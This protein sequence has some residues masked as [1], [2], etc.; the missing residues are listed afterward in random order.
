M[1]EEKTS[2]CN[3]ATNWKSFETDDFS[4]RY[5]PNFQ[6]ESLAG[7]RGLYLGMGVVKISF[8]DK[9]FEDENTTYRAAYLVVNRSSDQDEI[10]DCA[11]FFSHPGPFIDNGPRQ[12]EINGVTFTTRTIREGAAGNFYESQLYRSLH[13][14][15]C[16]EI[17]LVVHTVNR[18]NYTP[19]L[20]E[21]DNQKAYTRLEQ[22]R[23]TFSF[24]GKE[25]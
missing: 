21:F 18:Y 6:I 10:A 7:Q 14:G 5:P 11:K 17:A 20:Q 13:A 15:I 1:S 3:E 8:P 16:Y 12:V 25:K 4:L 2:S 19:P 23:D 9:A 24:K 22:I